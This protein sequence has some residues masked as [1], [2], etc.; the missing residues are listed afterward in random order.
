M[1]G[2]YHDQKKQIRDISQIKTDIL[3]T[4]VADAIGIHPRSSWS[5][6]KFTC[7]CDRWFLAHGQLKFLTLPIPVP[8]GFLHI[9]VV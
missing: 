4:S 9:V 8:K 7:H 6:S 3:V 2:R 1:K 5:A